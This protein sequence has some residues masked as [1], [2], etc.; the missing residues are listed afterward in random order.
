MLPTEPKA[1]DL[2]RNKTAMVYM[3][4]WQTQVEEEKFTELKRLLGVEWTREDMDASKSKSGGKQRTAPNEIFMPLASI[5]QPELIEHVKKLFGSTVGINAPTWVKRSE[6]VDLYEETNHEEFVN[7][8]GSFIRP[9][10]V[11]K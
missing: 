7:F 11:G 9:K 6:I 3:D 1:H 4:Y 2:W 5:I 8:M 10:V